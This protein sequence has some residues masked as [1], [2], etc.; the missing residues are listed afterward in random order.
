MSSA[1]EAELDNQ[2][3]RIIKRYANRKLYDTESSSYVTL[4]EIA[5]FVREGEDVQIIDN[6]SKEDIT[7]VTLAQI[8]YEEEKKGGSE[9]RR[10]N[11]LKH[12]IQE[13]R[14]RL[15]TSFRESPMS[16]L[17]NRQD[18]GEAIPE[19]VEEEGS[20]GQKSGLF[21]VSSPREAWD[22]L[23]RIAD[24]RMRT[25][26]GGALGHVQQLQ[27]EIMR[28]RSRIEELE[29]RLAERGPGSTRAA[30]R[31]AESTSDES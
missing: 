30:N 31:D 25:L 29:A 24:S 21:G 11:S 7:N 9:P 15:L 13:G 6:N 3:V 17:V 20:G 28:L 27:S 5:G 10:G 2:S 23:Q 1:S 8:I 22:E 12:F 26:L 4:H 14:Q 16:K 18:E 19:S